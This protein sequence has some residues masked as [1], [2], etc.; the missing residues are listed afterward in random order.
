METSLSCECELM[1]SAAALRRPSLKR[2][3]GLV[4]RRRR[5]SC[6]LTASKCQVTDDLASPA[7]GAGAPLR[8]APPPGAPFIE[9]EIGVF[10]N[11]QV[12]EGDAN[13]NGFPGGCRGAYAPMR[14]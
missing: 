2:L 12:A 8:F 4:P 10:L 13:Q 6:L 5:R 7:R 11:I 1:V 9:P 3:F 14:L